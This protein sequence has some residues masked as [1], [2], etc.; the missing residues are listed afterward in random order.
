MR[1]AIVYADRYAQDDT[2][3]Y[4]VCVVHL[5]EKYQRRDRWYIFMPHDAVAFQIVDYVKTTFDCPLVH[6]QP[7]L[8]FEVPGDTQL[9]QDIGEVEGE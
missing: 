9:Y 4:L 6:F 5:S 2:G 1:T 3:K 8:F 7:N